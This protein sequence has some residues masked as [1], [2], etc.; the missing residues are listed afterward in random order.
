MNHQE[1][2]NYITEADQGRDQFFNKFFNINP[3]DP[4]IYDIVLNISSIPIDQAV[5][6]TEGYINI[7]SK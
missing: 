2:I 7:Y 1:A 6:M 4:S 5:R 3:D